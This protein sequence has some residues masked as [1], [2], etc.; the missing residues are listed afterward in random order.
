VSAEVP[1]RAALSAGDKEVELSMPAPP[2]GAEALLAGPLE[3]LVAV[4]EG[5]PLLAVGPAGGDRDWA[6]VPVAGA[7]EASARAAAEAAVT[8]V[9]REP[10]G[11]DMAGRPHEVVM[12]FRSVALGPEVARALGELA[13]GPADGRDPAGATVAE[14]RA[15]ALAT[16]APPAS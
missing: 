4:R 8:L 14:L 2:G 3:V 5:V 1:H 12:G 6:A 11:T 13:A 15:L 16:H 10:G 9:L 7:R